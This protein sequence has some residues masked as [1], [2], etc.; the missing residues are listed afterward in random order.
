MVERAVR[1]RAGEATWVAKVVAAR[2][3]TIRPDETVTA[4]SCR[5]AASL[6]QR[7]DE[8]LPPKVEAQVVGEPLALQREVAEHLNDGRWRSRSPAGRTSASPPW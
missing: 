4:S 3:P 7:P 1:R 2:W 5:A 6:H 8:D